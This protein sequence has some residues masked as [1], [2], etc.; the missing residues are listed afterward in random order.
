VVSSSASGEP[1]IIGSAPVILDVSSILN[2]LVFRFD[3]SVGGN[4]PPESYYYSLNGGDYIDSGKLTSPITITGLTEPSPYSITLKAR[5]F[6]GDTSASDPL[7]GTPYVIGT[8]PVIYDIS[9]GINSM[10]VNFTESNR[11]YPAPIT[12]FYSIDGIEYIDAET[13]TSPIVIPRLTK[14]GP[15]NV[16]LVAYSLAGYTETSDVAVGRAYV[17]G[18]AP[19]ITE[20]TV[21][22]N[23][24]VM[25]F[26]NGG[27][28][29]VP[30]EYY[31]SIDGGNYLL[32][33]HTDATPLRVDNLV[34]N[35]E[36]SLSLYSSNFV[37]NSPVVT[38]NIFTR[39]QFTFY[40]QTMNSSYNRRAP[41]YIGP[42]PKS[43]PRLNG[44]AN[45]TA[46]STRAK[47]SRYVG[48]TAGSRR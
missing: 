3:G 25:Y 2:G 36:Y 41:I 15:Y 46:V 33:P 9:S 1:Y 23:D 22:F 28:Y 45:Q 31:Y 30:T 40:A 7:T 19:T 8:P 35:T 27:A 20:L 42:Q 5:N 17:V 21:N 24:F 37:G 13:T 18:E 4:P 32:I 11:G 14:F 39:S 34:S 6:V 16:T 48:G 47:F 44:G 38:I 12:Y 29:P 10:I 26:L 43:D